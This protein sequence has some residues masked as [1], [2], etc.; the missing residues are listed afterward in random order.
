MWKQLKPSHQTVI[1]HTE[2]EEFASIEVEKINSKNTSIARYVIYINIY[3]I[4]E[5]NI[6]VYKLEDIEKTLIVLRKEIENLYEEIEEN[7][8]HEIEEWIDHFCDVISEL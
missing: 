2:Y 4:T 5:Q 3:D 7:N 8:V 1:L 6:D